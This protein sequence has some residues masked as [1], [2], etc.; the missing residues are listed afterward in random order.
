MVY[1]GGTEMERIRI[2]FNNKHIIYMYEILSQ[3][4]PNQTKL[5]KYVA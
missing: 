1:V 5:E 4:Q 3:K 2:K